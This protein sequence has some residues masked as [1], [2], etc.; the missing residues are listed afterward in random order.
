M[1]SPQFHVLIVDD[2]PVVARYLASL[3]PSSKFETHVVNSGAECLHAM[4]SK[5]MAFDLVIMDSEMPVMDGL[6][7]L[8]QLRRIVS[9]VPVAMTSCY[10]SSAHTLEAWQCGAQEFLPKPILEVDIDRL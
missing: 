2:E 7:T 5:V 6:A 1:K 3:L 10:A 4:Q 9:N 8:R